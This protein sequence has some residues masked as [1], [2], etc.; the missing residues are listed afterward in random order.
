L[1]IYLFVL[2][3]AFLAGA[4]RFR[5][6]RPVFL[7]LFVP[8]LG[9]SLIA[10][11]IGVVLRTRG[12]HDHLFFNFFT[13]FEFLFYS[14]IYLRLIEQPRKRAIVRY[15]MLLYPVLF[16]VNMLFWEGFTH[17]HTITYRVGSVMVVVWCCFYFGELMRSPGYIS[18]LR[19]PSFWISTGLLFFYTG[20]FFYMTAG[21]K[22][23]YSKLKISDFIFDVISETLNVILYGC[24]LIG[25]VCEG[26][27]KKRS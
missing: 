17:F 25:F 16:L 21:D 19:N 20:F 10:E 26:S 15:G 23:I 24:F 8:F 5:Q 6:L 22:L 13:S 27:V 1:D 9:L 14:Y 18:I 7:R 2:A 11:G 12:I 4:V 3:A